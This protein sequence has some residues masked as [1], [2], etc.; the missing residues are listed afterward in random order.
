[1]SWCPFATK[2]ELQPE[3][4]GQPA[5]RPTQF[6]AHSIAAPWTPKRTYEYWRDRTVSALPGG[7]P[8]QVRERRA[9]KFRVVPELSE[10]VVARGTEQ[11]ADALPAGVFRAA[12]V[13]VVDGQGA[14][15]GLRLVAD[16]ADASLARQ[17]FRVAPP[18]A[19]R[20]GVL[21]C[22]VCLR[23]WPA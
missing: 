13:V 3:S 1:M 18:T 14:P 21:L 2:F 19:S 16:G 22:P 11:V 9:Q 20:A 4:D 7:V 10:A 15:V 23:C 12:S 6:I 8:L 5:I 17:H